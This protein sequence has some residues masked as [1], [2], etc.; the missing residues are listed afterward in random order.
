MSL[1][2][3]VIWLVFGGF[4]LALGWFIAAI[5]MA[6]S[7]IGL[8]WARACLEM[9]GLTFAPFGRAAVTAEEARLSDAF[10]RRDRSK[11]A[12][13]SVLSGLGFLAGILWLPFGFLLFLGHVAVGILLCLTIIGLPFGIQ[14]LKIAG[15]ALW[16]VGMRVMTTEGAEA[17][18]AEASFL[19]SLP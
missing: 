4:L 15:F 9:G 2:L 1:A 3:N 13:N 16:P 8:P 14:H 11:L 7:V 10:Q 17:I 12:G 6:L 18:R 5:V 19:R